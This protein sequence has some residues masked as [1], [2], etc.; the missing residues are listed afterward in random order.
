MHGK[1]EDLKADTE[2]TDR[3]NLLVFKL[4]SKACGKPDNYFLDII[5][6]KGHA[7]WYLNTKDAKKHSLCDQIRV[8]TYEIN[9]SVEMKL[10]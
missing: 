7:D 2:E 6:Q 4:L 1:V 10:I 8:P 3:L 5:H 9:V